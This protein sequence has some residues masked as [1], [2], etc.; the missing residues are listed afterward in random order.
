[1]KIA[2]ITWNK[3]IGTA[4]I[5]FS[6]EFREFDHFSQLEI[7]GDLS[8]QFGHIHLEIAKKIFALRQQEKK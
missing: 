2:S 7:L 3:N 5:K 4:E 6:Q 8:T 1:M